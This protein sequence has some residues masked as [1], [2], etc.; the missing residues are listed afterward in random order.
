MEN[1]KKLKVNLTAFIVLVAISYAMA[2]AIPEYYD[3][4]YLSCHHWALG[5][6]CVVVIG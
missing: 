4:D 1:V 3:W 2:S 5:Q 6:E